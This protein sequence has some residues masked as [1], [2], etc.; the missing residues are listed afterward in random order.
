MNSLWTKNGTP[1]QVAT[2][3][4]YSKSGRYVGEIHGDKVYDTSGQYAGTIVGDRVVYRGSD[5]GNAYGSVGRADMA[6]IGIAN[7]ASA[8]IWGEEPTRLL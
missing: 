3:A 1:L 2:T 7:R 4:V 8:G 5:S 6:G